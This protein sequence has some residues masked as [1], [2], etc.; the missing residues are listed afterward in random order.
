[1]VAGGERLSCRDLEQARHL[2]GVQGLRQASRHFGRPHVLPGI[3]ANSRDLGALTVTLPPLASCAGGSGIGSG[4]S[5][6]RLRGPDAASQRMR[7]ALQE[8]VEA[9]HRREP[10]L[11]AARPQTAR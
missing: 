6:L 5:L 7:L 2:V 11:D 10:P 1:T 9:A 8:L 3:A 4:G